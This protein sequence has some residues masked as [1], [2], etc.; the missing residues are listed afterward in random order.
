YD[1][2]I[3]A[4]PSGSL[5][6]SDQSVAEDN[7]EVV[8]ESATLSDG[9]FVAIHEGSASGD[10][11]GTSRY[12]EAGTHSNVRVDLD[13]MVNETTTLVAMPHL[14]DNSNNLYDFPEA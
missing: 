5:T 13:T 7:Q 14:D 3:L 4:E 11:I 1:G 2:R 12:L 8:V 6:F 10:V 9:G